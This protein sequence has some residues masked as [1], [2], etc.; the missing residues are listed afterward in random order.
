MVHIG[1]AEKSRFTWCL[2]VVEG[3][4]EKDVEEGE[5]G[6]HKESHIEERL[7]H[8]N[9]RLHLLYKISLTTITNITINHK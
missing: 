8:P 1:K 5:P 3:N 4:E 6:N 7:D 9:V 2:G